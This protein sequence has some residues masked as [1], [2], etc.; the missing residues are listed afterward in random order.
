MS[1]FV[2]HLMKKI[3][4]MDDPKIQEMKVD[5]QRVME[6]SFLIWQYKNFRI[7]TPSTR[8]TINI[9]IMES[10]CNYLSSKDDSFL[11]KNKNLISVNYVKLIFNEVYYDAVTRSTASKA[12]VLAR[13]RLAN[14]ILN[15]GTEG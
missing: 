13:F 15:E 3:N 9:A 8:G 12:K 11:E 2:E 7:P 6:K 5:F 4:K 14:E 10:V 1:D